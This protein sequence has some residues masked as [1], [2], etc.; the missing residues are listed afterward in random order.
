[1]NAFDKKSILWCFPALAF[2]LL[3]CFSYSTSPLY[4]YMG[5]D[6]A[7]FK[8]IGLGILQGKLPYT[9]LFDHKGPV[10]FYIDALGQWLIPGKAGIFL[11]QILSLSLALYFI[12]RTVRLFVSSKT[13]FISVLM[14]CF[15]L[16][17]FIEDGNHCEEWTLPFIC[18]SLYLAISWILD[19]GKKK[20]SLWKSL[21]YGC[22][23][24]FIFFI[25]PNDAV[26]SIGSVMF[27]VFMILITRR[28][29]AEA[30]AN[31]GVFLSG[32]GLAAL[33]VFA[34]FASKGIVEEMLFGT[35]F[36]NIA[37]ATNLSIKNIG[38]G[39]LLIPTLVLVLSAFL[40]RREEK[41]KELNWLLIPYL[42]LTLAL[43]GKRDYYHY[44]IPMIPYITI[45]FSLCFR[46]KIKAI[47]VVIC[48]LFAFGGF[49]QYKCLWRI[50]SE[51]G[52]LEQMYSQTDR[53]FANVPE[54]QRNGIWNYNMFTVNE[55]R[56]IVYS[57]LGV[58][59]HAGYTPGN[60]IF[61]PYHLPNFDQTETLEHNRPEWVMAY[62]AEEDAEGFLGKD[63]R[64]FDWTE[65]KIKVVLYRRNDEK[66]AEEAS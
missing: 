54:E 16:V 38:I 11:L 47:A 6:S 8:T 22:S 41:L 26:A 46:Q 35:I 29:Y 59:L 43:I 37:Y 17:D 36:Y 9:D 52:N 14:T 62:V 3:L 24:A 12:F 53:L 10:I 7:I 1:M 2:A 50:C 15:P 65:G 55:K 58:W 19:S 28:H 30:F 61:V 66:N 56:P 21:F 39:I 5:F 49:Y 44:L 33:P 31:A 23:F 32:C 34:Y 48:C 40:C 13:A 57:M 42:F 51:S 20:H 4:Q 60:R 27:A 63:Y 25:R 18:A 64:P 45:L